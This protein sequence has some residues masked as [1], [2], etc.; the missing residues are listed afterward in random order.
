MK[1]LSWV[2]AVIFIGFTAVQF[3]DIDALIWVAAYGSVTFLSVFRAIGRDSR[4]LA[5]VCATIYAAWALV[6]LSQ[7]N[8]QWWDGEIERETGGLTICCLWCLTIFL[9]RPTAVSRL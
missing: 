3:N 5:L 4:Y 6:L 9:I 7:T 1:V 2:M 8:G